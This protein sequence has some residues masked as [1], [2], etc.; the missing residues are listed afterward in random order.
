MK[1]G[2]MNE[3]ITEEFADDV[4]ERGNSAMTKEEYIESS[5]YV[6]Y[7]KEFEGILEQVGV[8]AFI[9]LIAGIITYMSGESFFYIIAG[10]VIFAGVPY[11]WKKVPVFSIGCLT[12]CI[13][14]FVAALAG[15]IITPIALIEKYA[16]MKRF[17]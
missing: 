14:L 11:A 9:G 1:D 8:G 13:K 6:Q 5:R 16:M 2:S 12:F 17:K 4:E 7:K 10:P 15:W 3:K